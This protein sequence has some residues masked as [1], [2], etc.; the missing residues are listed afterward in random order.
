[1]QR[2]FLV[3]NGSPKENI[4]VAFAELFGQLMDWL[5]SLPKAPKDNVT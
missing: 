2:L 1:L 5:N 3:Q 4:G